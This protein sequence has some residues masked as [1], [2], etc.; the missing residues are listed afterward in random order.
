MTRPSFPLAALAALLVL[1]GC[2]ASAPVSDTTSAEAT[3]AVSEARRAAERV[4]AAAGAAARRD[5]D[6]AEAALAA[7]DFDEAAHRAYLARQRVRAVA[8]QA[9]V[10]DAEREVAQAEAEGGRRLLVT[11][12]FRT[13]QTD[14][15][16]G[17]RAAV[18]HV[19]DYLV[20]NPSRVALV[21]GFTDSTGNEDRNLDLSV[22]RA[23][24]VKALLVEA[25]VDPARVVTAGY[26]QA[27]PVA[28]N[29][30]AEGQRQNRRIEVSFADRVEA[31]P[32]RAL[33]EPAPE[34]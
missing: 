26:G 8:L 30:T 18:G 19:A 28:T 27:Y 24:A 5:L 15:R 3:A 31:L 29:E 34:D 2:A 17:P 4:D 13:G 33:A 22:R 1:S 12:A 9:E 6:A 14:L 16:P 10:D 20:T 21:E 11:D 32:R 23:E 7:G 25:G